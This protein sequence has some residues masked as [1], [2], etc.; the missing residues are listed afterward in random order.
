MI[1]RSPL[2]TVF[3]HQL[4]SVGDIRQ[5]VTF[6]EAQWQSLVDGYRTLPAP[7]YTL[8]HRGIKLSHYVGVLKT[9]SVTLE[10][11]PKADA[12]HEPAYPKWR[13]LLVAMLAE[14]RYL[15]P[16]R[17]KA[18]VSS[19]QANT[20]LDFF[21]L[22]FLAEVETLCRQGL[23]KQY[24]WV[25]ENANTM[26]GQLL[27]AQHLRRNAVHQER[28]FVRYP[29]HSVQ[30]PLH[31]LLKRALY[32]VSQLSIHPQVQPQARRLL[33]YF[34]H[35]ADLPDASLLSMPVRYH[36]QTAPYQTAVTFARQILEAQFSH[37]YHGRTHQSFAL[38]LDMNRVFEEFVYKRLRKLAPLH[39]WVVRRQTVRQLWGETKVRPDI[40]VE[41]SGPSDCVVIDTKWKVLTH[42]RPAAEDLHQLYVYNQLFQAQ[43]GILLYPKVY[44]LPV[45]R[46][47]FDGPGE[48]YAELNYLEIAD[49]QRVGLS[50]RLDEQLV[51]MLQP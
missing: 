34:A 24:H 9:P 10:I 28:F 8:T 18:V 46:Q 14:C 38:L 50:P 16:Y 23:V 1:R 30:H 19:F 36:R 49:E 27:F 26:K 11:L 7:Y 25:E 17:S 20:L 43:K 32:L 22:D 31:Q 15:K 47:R 39:G 42:S 48:S 12:H 6:T 5:G 45:R 21:L 44:D 41:R 35:I 3:E 4:L 37:V 51:R 13:Q 2:I 40:V 29:V 33:H